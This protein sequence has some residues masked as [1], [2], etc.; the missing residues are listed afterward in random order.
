MAFSRV[1][2]DRPTRGEW[3]ATWRE[4]RHA[5]FF[6]SPAWAEL[7]ETVTD[8]KTESVPERITF[9]DGSRAILPLCYE[10]KY[11]GLLSRYVA[12]PAAT[13]GGWITKDVLSLEQMSVLLDHLLDR[14]Q[15]L[16]WRMNPY[17]ELA[18]RAGKQRGL[19]CKGDYTHALNLEAGPD[20][21]LDEFTNGYRAD[22]KKA[23]KHQRISIDRAT[24]LDEW[25]AYYRVYQD[26]L[27][28]WGHKPDEGYPWK[29]F[30]TMAGLNCPDIALWLGRYDGAIVSGEL[31]LYARQHV[32]SWHAATL[33][34][35]LRTNVAKVQIFHVIKDA[36]ARGYRWFDFNP[37]AG[38]PGVRVFKESFNAK[39]L[40][41]PL[42]YVD[43]SV[44]RRIRGI[45]SSMGIPY[46]KLSLERLEDVI[47]PSTRSALA[48]TAGAPN[49]PEPGVSVT[50]RRRS[51]APPPP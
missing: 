12:S 47:G 24:T 31:C 28:R 44:K 14:S 49:L 34:H 35:H 48:A 51:T 26:T 10:H 50:P 6:Q 23:A 4:C 43:S 8:R 3:Q 39:A 32:V 45:A 5:T 2:L 30:Q 46:A 29:L 42:V 33:E 20:A 38:L 17:D 7:W 25:H 21:L 11:H 18:F 19:R 1:Q 27:R 13:F 15:S 41:A 37:S 16:V 36:C 22:V 9:N 40:P